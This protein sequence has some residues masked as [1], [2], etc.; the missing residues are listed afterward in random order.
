MRAAAGWLLQE[1][2]MVCCA[3]ANDEERAWAGLHGAGASTT[4]NVQTNDRSGSHA[5]RCNARPAASP[6]S[7]RKHGH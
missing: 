6:P 3:R 7:L 1:L 5:L 2:P 4:N